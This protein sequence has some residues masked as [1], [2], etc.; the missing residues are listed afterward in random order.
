MLL[1]EICAIQYKKKIYNPVLTK[2]YTLVNR[3]IGCWNFGNTR[4]LKI[5]VLL[6]KKKKKKINVA[7]YCI[8]S[9]IS[10]KKNSQPLGI[11]LQLCIS[12]NEKQSDW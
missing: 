7:L 4:K 9:S 6:L 2:V 10:R 12:L 8:R 1:L 11:F 5:I 3:Q